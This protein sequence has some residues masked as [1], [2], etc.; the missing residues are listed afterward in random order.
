MT[1]TQ[2]YLIARF[3]LLGRVSTHLAN[4]RV[5]WRMM[6]IKGRDMQGDVCCVAMC[7][8]ISMQHAE[9]SCPANAFCHLVHP[10]H[11]TFYPHLVLEKRLVCI[12]TAAEGLWRTD[13][14]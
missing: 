8:P 6:R 13:D 3:T 5:S 7:Q 4:A 2:A 10:D 14:V 12:R 9:T 1:S 11:M